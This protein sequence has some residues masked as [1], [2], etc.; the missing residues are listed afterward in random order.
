MEW[1]VPKDVADIRLFMGLAGYYRRFLEGF[2]RVAYP[3]TSLQKKG[4]IF[5][6]TTECQQSFEQLKHLLTTAPVLSIA[7]L[8]KD[9][10][11][12]TD[13]SKEG[14][15]GVLMQEGKVIAYESRKLKEH[16]QKYSAYDL[17]LTVVVHALKMWRHYLLGKK[18][19]LMTDHH[20]LTSYFNQPTLNARQ[21]RWV[22][23]LSGFDFEIKHLKGKENRV[24]DELSRKMH[25]L[26]EIATSK[27]WVTLHEEIKQAGEQDREYQQ[28]KQQVQD[29]TNPLRK[30]G[31]EIK[32]TGIL[33]YKERIYIPNHAEIKEKILNEHHK[34]PYEG[35]PGY[36]K[37]I[38]AVRKECY[39]PGMK[40]EVMDYLARCIVCQQVKAEHQHPAGLLQPLPIPEWKWE[41]ITIDFITGLPKSKKG[42]DSIMVVVD[43]LSK[44]AHFIPVQSTYRAAQIENI[45]MHNIFRLH[46][47]PKTIISDRD[48]K[49]TSAFWKT[50]FE[51]LGTQLN[52]ITAYHPQTDGQTE[53]VHQVVED[54]LRAY[55][56]Q[57]PNRWEEYIHLVEFAYNNGYHASLQMSPFEVL[58]GRKCHTPSSW[59]GPED[60][61]MLGPEM[62]K[63]MEQ[64][65][66]KVQA[67]LKVAQDRQK[68]Y[69]D[70]KRNFKEFHVGEHVYVRIRAKKSTLQ[71]SGCAKLAPRF[72]GPFQ[73]LG[74]IGPVAYQLA[75]PSHIRVHNVFHV[76]V[77]K[78]YIYDP[79]HI[80]SWQDIQVEPEGEFPV[81]PVSIL[82]RRRVVLRK[83][84]I[85]QV[86]V[87]WQHF[88]PDEA[89]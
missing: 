33:Y 54:M 73:I 7:D 48:V 13:A 89:T 4:R 47:L 37:L 28:K 20:S 5:K 82:D 87:Q 86:K 55:V 70:Q 8:E 64:M 76:S 12:C 61:I 65:V 34:S 56:M 57:Q 49:F 46:G 80:I 1:P 45:F 14:V 40:K 85:I 51:G 29:V 88:G 41:V 11:V 39:W 84:A 43:K 17:E 24:A 53:R 59:G 22:D 31:Y 35:H 25:C 26:Y 30:Q 60:K 83:R 58:Y 36:Q 71:W 42:N 15:G 10:V 3:I 19:L 67:N 77:L 16:E 79:K 75:L 63:E 52:F 6:W 81:K 18:F 38:T 9:Y 69:A 62:L 50:L 2:S 78:K 74:R 44:S 72:C 68:S 21:A 23:F 27:G 66:K 32:T